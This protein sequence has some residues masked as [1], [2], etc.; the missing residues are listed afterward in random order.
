MI[1]ISM[2]FDV[3][4]IGLALPVK[5]LNVTLIGQTTAECVYKQHVLYVRPI[6]SEGPIEPP[7]L[8]LHHM[9][10]L[11]MHCS[12]GNRNLAVRV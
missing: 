10:I 7:E 2:T 4:I 8:S 6:A 3:L 1:T 5:R 11:Q 12:N 9:T